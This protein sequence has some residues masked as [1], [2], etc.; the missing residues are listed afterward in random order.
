MPKREDLRL[1]DTI[2]TDYQTIRFYEDNENRLL[3]TL[4]TYA[5]FKEGEDEKI[6]HQ[7]LISPVLNTYKDRLNIGVLILGGGDGLVA[8]YL[9]KT[10]K[11]KMTL[12]DIDRK[13]VEMFS[14]MDELVDINEGS[15]DR[16]RKYYMDAYEW[17]KLDGNTYN[18]IIIDLPDPNSEALEKLYTKEF[19]KNACEL[20]REGGVISIQSNYNI[21]YRI[22]RYIQEILGNHKITEYQAPFFGWGAVVS[23]EQWHK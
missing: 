14:N 19:Y 6:Y 1:I 9:L 8:K 11:A 23:G 7:A 3:M 16:C 13:L 12:V 20:L 22:A 17:V 5:Q 2:K 15:L 18:A 4:D 21:R 10:K